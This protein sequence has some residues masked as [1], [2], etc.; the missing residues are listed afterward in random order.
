MID[1]GEANRRISYQE[2]LPS[3]PLGDPPEKISSTASFNSAT[4]ADFAT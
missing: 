4:E 3:P 2:M 1:V